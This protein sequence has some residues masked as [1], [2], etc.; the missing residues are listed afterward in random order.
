MALDVYLQKNIGIPKT[1]SRCFLQFEDNGY[2]WFLYDFFE[3]L[4]KQSGQMI[5]L[6]DGA[7]FRGGNLDLLNF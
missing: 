6:Y 3:D 4:A 2:Y 7:F 5:D 1:F